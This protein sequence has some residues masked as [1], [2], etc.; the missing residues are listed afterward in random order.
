MNRISVPVAVTVD[1]IQT[2]ISMHHDRMHGTTRN[3]VEHTATVAGGWG[4]G[5]GGRIKSI[6]IRFKIYT[7]ILYE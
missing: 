3:T 6:K 1:V 4:G 2:G 5:Y 7:Q